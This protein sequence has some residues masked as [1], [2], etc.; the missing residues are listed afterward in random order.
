[1]TDASFHETKIAELMKERFSLHASIMRA[2]EALE[3]GRPDAAYTILG[4]AL[5]F[6][7][8]AKEDDFEAQ[9]R[10]AEQSLERD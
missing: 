1:M 9:R 6:T 8:P 4:T 3:Q 10:L 7:A 2:R 5:G